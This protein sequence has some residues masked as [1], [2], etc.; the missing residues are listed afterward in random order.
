M[1]GADDVGGWNSCGGARIRLIFPVYLIWSR[2]GHY[3]LL[4]KQIGFDRNYV[5]RLR[6]TSTEKMLGRIGHL[7]FG[8]GIST[9]IFDCDGCVGFDFII[10][11]FG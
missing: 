10:G 4:Y 6:N 1:V 5:S 11:N 8:A 7:F 2:A 9:P 3:F